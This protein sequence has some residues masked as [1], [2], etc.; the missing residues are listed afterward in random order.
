MRGSSP[1]VMNNI[2]AGPDVELDEAGHDSVRNQPAQDSGCQVA[3]RELLPPDVDDRDEGE[4]WGGQG[5]D[6]IDV[7]GRHVQD[8]VPEAQ[9][10]GEEGGL[11]A[12]Q[13]LVG[14]LQSQR[15]R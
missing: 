15:V 1:E 14:A 4:G 2:P 10:R 9:A 12:E 7:A 5:T 6:Y 11:A 13:H 8:A 3:G